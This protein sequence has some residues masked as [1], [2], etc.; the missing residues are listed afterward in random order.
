LIESTDG[1]RRIGYPGGMALPERW[2]QY[3]PPALWL[4][5]YRPSWLPADVIAGVTLAAYAVP[6]ALAY[7]ALAGMPPEAGIYGYMLGGIG[8][9]LLGS[10]RHLAVGPTSAISLMVAGGVATVTGGDTG[11][12]AEV[13]TLAAFAVAALC[14]GAW[15]ARLSVLTTLISDSI[16]VG[17]KAGAGI[18][19]AVTQ[20]PALFGLPGG[21]QNVIERV[22]RLAGQMPGFNEPTLALGLLAL[23]LLALGGRFL[24][25]RPV[26]LAVVVM[27]IAA[28]A[29]LELPAHGVAVTGEVP[30]GLPDLVVPT[31]RL[32]EVEGIFPLAAG[33]LLLAYVEGVSAA[34]GLA[35][36]HGYA[37]NPRQE[38]LGIGAA[39]LLAGFA[40]GYP[41][42]GGLSQSAVSEAAGAKTPLALIFAS[43]AL[44]LSLL[45]L[46]G[47]IADLPRAVLSGVV[48]HAVAG[49]VD[50]R[51]LARLWRLSRADFSA[52]AV[53]L[54]G[55][56]LLG[57]LQGIMLAALAS[58]LLL[59][60]ATSRPH[61][62]FLGRIPGTSLYSDMARHTDNQKV[63]GVLL[64][65]PEGAVLYVSA[66]SIAATVL[67]RLDA[68]PEG[69]THLV[70]CDLTAS[71]LMDL[72]GVEMLRSLHDILAERGVRLV[73]AGTLGRVRDLMRREGF[74]ELVGGVGRDDT[75]ESVL[76]REGL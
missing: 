20:L 50:V 1:G 10:S 52:A 23:L 48:L 28:S 25:G 72:A 14:L 56:V 39:N 24:P 35:A 26:A 41:V 62:A 33:C 19:I 7:A 63:P 55:V 18:T 2:S 17:F 21:G 64:F 68:E 16:L 69:S 43:G 34:R 47:W 37:I 57:I 67:E 13:A 6:V 8:Y 74:A 27:A 36:K 5:E 70:V 11:H 66:E 12:H 45:F 51:A 3:F 71:P 31:L 54:V 9:A 38:F 73:L 40:Q 42:A 59:L 46:T 15:L 65:R 22:V 61:V 4:V 75:V 60:V 30:A 32:W 58:V 76:A 49:L 53:A 29:M 44:A